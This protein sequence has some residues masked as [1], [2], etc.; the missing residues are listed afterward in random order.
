MTYTVHEIFR[1]IQGEGANMGR[2]AVFVR[3]AGC[4]LW[5][6]REEDRENAVC[7]FCDTEFRKGT[8]YSRAE[9]VDAIRG[10]ASG[11]LIVFTGGEPALQLDQDLVDELHDSLGFE[12]AIETNGTRPIPR[13]QWVCV[14]PKAGTK[15]AVSRADELKLVFPQGSGMTPDAAM[16]AVDAPHLWLSP[17][18]GPAWA[19]N[20]RQAVDY[21]HGD[22]RWRLNIQAHKFWRIP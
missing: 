2:A 3:F 6:G 1:T 20:V 8:R 22:P 7:S 21:I 4:N 15:L 12:I 17:M 16:N 19:D 13:V 14:S 5:S 18:D 9:L 10:L 11:G